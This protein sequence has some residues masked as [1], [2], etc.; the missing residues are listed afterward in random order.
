M[1]YPHYINATI[2]GVEQ[3]VSFTF[4]AHLPYALFLQAGET[5]LQSPTIIELSHHYDHG[6]Y[7]EATHQLL[8]TF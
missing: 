1:N 2:R 7:A 4:P 5:L 8:L 3:V 6:A